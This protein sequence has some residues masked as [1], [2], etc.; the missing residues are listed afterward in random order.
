MYLSQ[1][2]EKNNVHAVLTVVCKGGVQSPYAL[3][4]KKL[5]I[6]RRSQYLSVHALCWWEKKT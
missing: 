6:A 4:C 2:R 5:R 3:F 1:R